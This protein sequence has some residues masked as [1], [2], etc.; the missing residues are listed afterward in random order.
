MNILNVNSVLYIYMILSCSERFFDSVEVFVFDL[1][2]VSYC[3]NPDV[4]F[5]VQALVSFVV[6]SFEVLQ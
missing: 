6:V 2:T 4:V 5:F 3:H 1:V